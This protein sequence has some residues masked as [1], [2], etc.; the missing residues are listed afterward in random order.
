MRQAPLLNGAAPRTAI[1]Q[2]L[3]ALLTLCAAVVCGSAHAE[4]TID[5]HIDEAEWQGAT[6]CADWQRT[7][8]FARDQ[9]RYGNELR[10]LSTERGLAAAFIID[11]P[12]AERRIK[13]R[14][15]RDSE[16]LI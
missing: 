8:P 4:L 13:P 7:M 6:V 1:I 10:I 2:A 14:T 12:P 15:P 5:G 3:C 9:P 16:R 11:Q